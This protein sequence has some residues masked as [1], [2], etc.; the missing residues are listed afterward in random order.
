MSH[1]RND[2]AVAQDAARLNDRTRELR[3]FL[4][5]CRVRNVHT[6]KRA[7]EAIRLAAIMPLTDKQ[8]EGRG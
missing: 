1:Q 3:A 2:A 8:R 7:K 5:R 4:R 6:S